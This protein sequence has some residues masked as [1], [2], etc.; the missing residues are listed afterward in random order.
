[1]SDAGT[2]AGKVTALYASVSTCSFPGM[3]L[4]EGHQ[5][6]VMRKEGYMLS[7][8]SMLRLKSSL[9]IWPA[10][11]RL[12]YDV[13]RAEV[14]SVKIWMAVIGCGMDV[15]YE[16]RWWLAAVRANSSASKLVSATLLCIAVTLTLL[17][18]P[19]M[20]CLAPLSMASLPV[21]LTGSGSV[22]L[23]KQ[24]LK[25]Q[26]SLLHSGKARTIHSAQPT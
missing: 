26:I 2:S 11:G 19:D 4:C 14:L 13:R 10:C 16:Y 24:V 21:E 3:P 6:R 17:H 15:T 12:S 22:D 9:S 8:S 7:S 25:Q 18:S 23:P 1:M 20:Y 5:C